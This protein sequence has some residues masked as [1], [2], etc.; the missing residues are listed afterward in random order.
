MEAATGLEPVNSGFADRRSKLARL[1]LPQRYTNQLSTLRFSNSIC[2]GGAPSR[3][4][5]W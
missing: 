4:H 1:V 5:N 2:S 3:V